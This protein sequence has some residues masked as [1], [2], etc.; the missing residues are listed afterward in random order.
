[1]SRARQAPV[2]FP[3]LRQPQPGALDPLGKLALQLFGR[4]DVAAVLITAGL[5]VL[6]APPFA[7]C[8]RYWP[9]AGIQFLPPAAALIRFSTSVNMTMDNIVSKSPSVMPQIP[10]ST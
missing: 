10:N 3:V 4:L 9:L 6:D 5:I 8:T 1:M 2:F 7:R